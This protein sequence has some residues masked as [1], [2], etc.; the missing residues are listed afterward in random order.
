MT[1]TIIIAIFVLAVAL[2]G[3]SLINSV[4]TAVSARDAAIAEVL[5]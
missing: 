3:L 2:T 4:E 1:K 5:K